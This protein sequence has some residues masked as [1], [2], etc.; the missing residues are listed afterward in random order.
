MNTKGNIYMEEINFI[1]ESPNEKFNKNWRKRANWFKND[2][3]FNI[4]Y[5]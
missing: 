5:F 3:A 1:L 2:T 4:Q